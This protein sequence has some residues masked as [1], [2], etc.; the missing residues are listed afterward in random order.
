MMTEA[1]IDARL[2]ELL[3]EADPTEH[4]PAFAEKIVSLAASDLARRQW[5]RRTAVRVGMETAAFG[6]VLASFTLLA[7]AAPESAGFG[8]SIPLTSPAMAGLAVLL[9]WGLTTLSPARR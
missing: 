2:A 1:D 7:R 5:F 6:A 9:M 8:D 3:R 4:D